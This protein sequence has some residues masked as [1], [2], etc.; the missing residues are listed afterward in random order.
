M[1][2]TKLIDIIQIPLSAKMALSIPYIVVIAV[3]GLIILA[4]LLFLLTT[5]YLYLD[6]IWKL[7][8]QLETYREWN[9]LRKE[10]NKTAAIERR[11][12]FIMSII[13]DEEV[14]KQRLSEEDRFYYAALV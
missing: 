2:S 4:F 5:I 7:T 3:G 14:Q 6:N 12:R 1:A 10:W 9:R 13:L 11:R 8:R